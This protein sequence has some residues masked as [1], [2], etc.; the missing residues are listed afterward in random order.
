M[1][2][3]QR[4]KKVLVALI[5][6]IFAVVLIVLPGRE[7]LDVVIVILSFGFAIKGIKDIVFYFMMARHM[8][9]GKMILFQGVVVLDFAMFTGSLSGVPAFYV[10]LY[11]IAIHAFS[12]IVEVLRAMESKRTVAGSWALK[13]SHGVINI[14]LALM[15]IVFIMNTA[16]A[17]AIY[18]VG[19]MYSALIHMISAFRRTTFILIK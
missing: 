6:F 11:L 12:G 14:I 9:G 4:I 7:G 17:V 13:M 5:M 15:C 8:V 1:T 19:L 10:M 16:T 3:F 2:L 18:S